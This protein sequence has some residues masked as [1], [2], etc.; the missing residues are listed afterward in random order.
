MGWTVLGG[1]MPEDSSSKSK[2]DLVSLDDEQRVAEVLRDSV[3]DL[4]EVVNNLTRIRRT[5]R[6]E[7]RVTIFGSARI[8]KD[9]W[10]Y[11]AVR[12]L[13]R[14]LASMG[15][16]IVTG[17]GPG[18]MEAANEGAAQAGLDP[19][20]SVGI[21]VDLPFEQEIN[22]FVQQAYAHRTFFSRL[23]HFVLVSDAFVVV[24]GGI[25]TVLELSMIWQLLQV[26]NLEHTPLILIGRM[27]ADFVAWAREY[28]LRPEFELAS[29]QDLEIPRCVDNAE[30]AMKIIRTRYEEW[31][32]KQAGQ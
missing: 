24:P 17:G 20:K 13:A 25:G 1:N 15:C 26:R 30:Q 9:H 4:W 6:A 12:D 19:E 18:L 16:A 21:R 29:L 27:W 10:V 3:M 32:Q 23:H 7:F 8:P 11:G 22:P 31:R 14:D 28:L 2:S 5:R